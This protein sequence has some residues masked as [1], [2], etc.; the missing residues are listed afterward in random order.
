[1]L[2]ENQFDNKTKEYAKYVQEFLGGSPNAMTY[3]TKM[4]NGIRVS[5]IETDKAISVELFHDKTLEINNPGDE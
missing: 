4:P 1:M 2:T 5:F 3:F